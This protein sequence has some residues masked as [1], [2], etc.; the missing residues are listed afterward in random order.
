MTWDGIQ[1]LDDADQY[2]S[3]NWASAANSQ[4]SPL[5]VW[6]IGAFLHIVHPSPFWEFPIVHLVNFCIAV[7]SLAGFQFFLSN[8]M[9]SL[10]GKLGA[11]PP[12]TVIVIGYASFL[13]ATLDFTSLAIVT[14]DLLMHAFV[15]FAAGLLVRIA[16]GDHRVVLLF[17]LGFVFDAGYL[18]KA[19][20]LFYAVFCGAI[21]LVLLGFKLRTVSRLAV[22]AL[23]FLILA[24]PYIAFLSYSKHRLTYGDSGRYNV[25]WMLNGVPYYHWQGQPPGSGTPLH[26]TR[27]ISTDPPAYEFATPIAGTYPPW[28]DPIYWNQGAQPHYRI[29]EIAAA[30]VRGLKLYEYL[31]HRRQLALV[32]GLLILILAAP[33]KLTILRRLLAHAALLAFGLFP[34][35]MYAMV[36]QDARFLRLIFRAG[37]GSA[38][39]RG[40]GIDAGHSDRSRV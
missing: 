15:Y 28:F 19:P 33:T 11:I 34:F 6:L 35:I 37:M 29:R 13:Y 39:R 27:Q 38:V 20:C 21:L 9:R 31:I 30:I 32:A 40:P 36:H 10:S 3:G 2:F 4:W 7:F 16:A 5:Y 12:W 24:G 14:P 18:A 1:Y 26:P 8:L 23:G 22:F 25:V 17:A